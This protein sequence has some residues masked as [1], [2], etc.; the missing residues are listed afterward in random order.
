MYFYL[1]FDFFAVAQEL[2]QEHEQVDEVEIEVQRPH[3]CRLGQPFAVHGLSV[4]D[5]VGLDLLGVIGGEASKD[6]NTDHRDGERQRTRRHEHVDDHGDDQADQAHHQ[7]RTHTRQVTFRRVA[8]E[9]EARETGRGSQE[10]LR[11]R[12]A[13]EGRKDP[14]DRQAHCS[15]E[16]VEEGLCACGRQSID[17]AAE[18]KDHAQRQEH[19]N[20]AENVRLQSH[21]IAEYRQKLGA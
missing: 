3:D 14:R 13:G 11:D 7:E 18:E 9:A 2:Q 19:G 10:G 20:P 4:H 8:P 16:D 21:R 12:S 17:H 1:F 6:Q 5:V 15:G